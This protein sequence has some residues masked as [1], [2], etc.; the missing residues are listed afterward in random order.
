MNDIE[1]I[2]GQEI[3]EIMKKIT[4][5]GYRRAGT[6]PAIETEKF[7]AEKL[8]EAGIPEVKLEE[9]NFPR[10][11]VA[12]NELTIIGNKTSLVNSD[13]IIETFPYFLSGSTDKNGIVTEMVYVGNGTSIDFEKTSVDNKIALIEGKMILN[14]H[15]THHEVLFNSLDLAK[16]HGALGAVFI[17]G[18]PLDSITYISFDSHICLSL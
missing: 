18:S 12:K 14:F 17:N 10:W 2:K 9:F 16:S 13:Q 15:P 8:K 4:E 3:Y 11:N 1:A 5:F 6:P 7:I